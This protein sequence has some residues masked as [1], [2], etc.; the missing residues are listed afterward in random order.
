MVIAVPGQFI[1]HNTSKHMIAV[2]GMY[3][4]HTLITAAFVLI[5][6]QTIVLYI[7]YSFQQ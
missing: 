6:S 2:P 1:Q 3:L 7:I 5:S 4:F